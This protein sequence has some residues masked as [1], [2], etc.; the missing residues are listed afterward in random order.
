MFSEEMLELLIE[1]KWPASSGPIKVRDM[2]EDH[3]IRASW[4]CMAHR[5]R[6]VRGDQ[7]TPSQWIEVF[8][9]E[10]ERRDKIRIEQEEANLRPTLW[11]SLAE[12]FRT[13]K[14]RDGVKRWAWRE[15]KRSRRLKSFA[16]A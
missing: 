15:S 5:D 7:L 2:S 4:Y 9:Y 10:M 6:P 11:L 3:L 1:S 8:N 16:S 12:G 13:R 14:K